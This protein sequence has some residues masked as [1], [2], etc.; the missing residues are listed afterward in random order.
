MHD[1]TMARDVANPFS[2]LSAY[3]TTTATMSPRKE[4]ND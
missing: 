1:K 4:V 3:L 2:M